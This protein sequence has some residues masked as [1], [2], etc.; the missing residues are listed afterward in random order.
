M[1]GEEPAWAGEI[2]DFWFGELGRE[3]W[4]AKSPA[5]D[6]TVRARFSGLHGRLAASP[7][8]PEGASARTLLAAVIALDQFPRHMFRDTAKA[9][10]TDEIALG[11]AKEA[12]ARGLDRELD[13][14]ERHCLYLPFQ[15]GEI[16]ADQDRACALYE[17]L[18]DAEGLDFARRHK[19]IIDR[20]ARFPHRNAQL[21]RQ[22]TPE[23][24]AFL[25]QPG[26]GF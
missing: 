23:E 14:R 2:L 1:E 7:P 8:D 13:P 24:T 6:A 26:S 16:A 15:H 20:F 17:E 3:D 11:L 18:G 19:A 4:Y 9:F 10:A 12:V 25:K 5:L 22:S 21:G